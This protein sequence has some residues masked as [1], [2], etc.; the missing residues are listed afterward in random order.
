MP[1]D[2]NTDYE[3]GEAVEILF[4]PDAQGTA[5]TYRK[6]T[7]EG[8]LAFGGAT[9]AGVGIVDAGEVRIVQEA[10]SLSV[11]LSAVT[12]E[13]RSLF[14]GADYGPVGAKV[15]FVWRKRP[16]GGAWTEWAA[17]AIYE[18]KVSTPLYEGGAITIEIQRVFDDVWRGE[19]LRWTGAEQRR[20]FPGDT[21]L[22][23]A[24]RA[25]RSG[26]LIGWQAF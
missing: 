13:E 1:L 9:Y 19:V 11:V 5:R 14:L 15:S 17:T 6:W 23:R 8:S 10:E 2:A 20:R 21:G 12:R 18:G 25:R 16:S 7:G 24:D 22:D 26:L 4:P 3:V